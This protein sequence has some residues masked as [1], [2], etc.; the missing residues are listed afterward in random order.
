V[1]QFQTGDDHTEL[2]TWGVLQKYSS[3]YQIPKKALFSFIL[4]NKYRL[5]RK[6]GLDNAHP[7]F[8]E[9]Y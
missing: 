4:K 7:P 2:Q 6:K 8:T 9:L 3:S 1:K 5:L